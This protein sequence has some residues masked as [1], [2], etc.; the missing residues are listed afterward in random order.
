MDSTNFLQKPLNSK[1]VVKKT[2]LLSIEFL[3][4]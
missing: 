4:D 1:L 2:L 3:G